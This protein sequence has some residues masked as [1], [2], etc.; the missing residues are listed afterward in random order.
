MKKKVMLGLCLAASFTVLSMA[1]CKKEEA[2]EVPETEP[3]VEEQA[4]EEEILKTIGA[5]AE[6]AF[7]V[8][9][10]NNT[11]K[12]IK[13]ISIK[14]IEEEEFP[15]NFLAENDIYT[16]EEAR[17][18][19]YSPNQEAK[20][21]EA[22]EGDEDERLLTPGYDIRLTF[23]D[24]TVAVLH[25]F[26]FEDIEEGE[27]H[28]EEEVGFIKYTSVSTNET[29]ETKE[30][31]LAIKE[32]ERVAAEEA[33]KAAEEQAAAEKAAA[34]EQAAAEKAAANKAAAK[35]SSSSTSSN[36]NSSS[37]NSGSSGGGNSSDD[38]CIGDDGLTY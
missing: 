16:V 14:I 11:G 36:S 2:K 29:V 1:G 17:Y 10:T 27:L 6:G 23:S 28:L 20:T 34:E 24:D 37:G 22:A 21:E 13:G 5:E 8:R 26:P 31:E 12:D 35:A 33:Q 9:L 25:S 4:E 7:K 3:V 18:L 30:A 19:Y 32:Q 15:E 38:G